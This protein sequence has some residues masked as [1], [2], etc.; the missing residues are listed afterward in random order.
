MAAETKDIADY[1]EQHTDEILGRW[2]SAAK[3]ESSQAERLSKMDDR[4]LLDH[5]PA[6]TQALIGALRG[7]EE[8]LL[9][10]EARHHGHQRRLDGYG[11]TDV[12]WEHTIFR[13]VF[14]AVLDEASEAVT[15]CIP[16]QAA[17][18]FWTCWI[19]APEPPSINTSKIQN[20]SA[21]ELLRGL[22]SSKL[23]AS[24]FSARSRTSFGTRSSRSSSDFNVSKTATPLPVSCA[25]S[26]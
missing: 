22:T 24:D 20:R 13:R 8:S 3:A 16:V 15:G 18:S 1:L 2:R 19:V 5:L 14:L 12:L 7:E 17:T 4:E 10:D 26:R 9:E 6:V 23:N 25:R 11:V 21:T